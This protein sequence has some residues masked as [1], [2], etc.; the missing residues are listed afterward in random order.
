[1]YQLYPTIIFFVGIVTIVVVLSRLR[2]WPHVIIIIVVVNRGGARKH[3]G[4]LIIF[5][6]VL[7]RLRPRAIQDL[8][9]GVESVWSRRPG[10]RISG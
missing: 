5:V 2:K 1:M 8:L 3:A 4:R 9:E 10:T 6:E 7:Q